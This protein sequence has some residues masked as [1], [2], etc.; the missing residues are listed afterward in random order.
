[1][2]QG[3]WW[4]GPPAA[5][6]GVCEPLDS[7]VVWFTGGALG[8]LVHDFI[9][10]DPLVCWAP[11]DLDFN[12]RLPLAQGCY[13]LPRLEGVGLA[14]TRLVVRH[15]LAFSAASSM[16]AHS[17]SYASWVVPMWVFLPVQTHTFFQTTA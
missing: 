17:A 4:H 1:V 10:G 9:P 11:T 6:A 3:G 15:R 12:S 2:R 8:P 14:Q 7:V 5:L 16:A 13:R